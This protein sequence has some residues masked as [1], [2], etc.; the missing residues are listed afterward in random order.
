METIGKLLSL[1]FI[2]IVGAG[3]ATMFILESDTSSVHVAEPKEE[4]VEFTALDSDLEKY[5]EQLRLKYIEA[6]PV[7]DNDDMEN[8]K[9]ISLWTDT[10]N[11]SLPDYVS[12]DEIVNLAN[13]NDVG[14]LRK[15]MN[16]WHM[17]YHQALKNNKSVLANEAYRMHK[18]YKYALEYKNRSF[19]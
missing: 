6:K 3:G 16:A 8:S 5:R 9:K 4:V 13:S 18:N 1:I 2:A 19:K 10:F 11:K 14:T 15:E 7:A 17:R 12:E